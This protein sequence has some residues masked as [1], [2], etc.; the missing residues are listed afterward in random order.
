MYLPVLVL[1]DD[2]HGLELVDAR[3]EDGARSKGELAGTGVAVL[4]AAE[5]LA[6]GTDASGSEV[7]SAGDGGSA[8]VEPVIVIGRELLADASLDVLSP[9]G[10][11]EDTSGLE[12]LGVGLDEEVSGDVLDG[13]ATP[14]SRNTHED[15]RHLFIYVV[16]VG[17]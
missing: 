10:S 5:S 15:G 12:L 9:L 7:E 17:G 1:L 2:L 4:L 8:D 16:V 13:H 6:E 3:A 14:A 11:L